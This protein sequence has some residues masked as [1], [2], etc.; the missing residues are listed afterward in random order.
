MIA[1]STIMLAIVLVN[2]ETGMASWEFSETNKN[3]FVNYGKPNDSMVK[4]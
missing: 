2:L 4:V 1:M 3:L